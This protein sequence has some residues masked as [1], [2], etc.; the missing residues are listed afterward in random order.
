MIKK[1]IHRLV[2]F[3]LLVLSKCPKLNNIYSGQIVQAAIHLNYWIQD[4][5]SKVINGFVLAFVL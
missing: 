2:V 5:C 1:I 4:I 3:A